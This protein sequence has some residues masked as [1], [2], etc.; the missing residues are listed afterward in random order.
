MTYG[1]SLRRLGDGLDT[2]WKRKEHKLGIFLEE[3][4]KREHNPSFGLRRET[5]T[6]QTFWDR[7]HDH[8][9]QNSFLIDNHLVSISNLRDYDLFSENC[10]TLCCSIAASQTGHI[11]ESGMRLLLVESQLDRRSI[12][13]S[14]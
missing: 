10:M 6:H 3:G 12:S 2:N 8:H 13:S 1:R 11:I 9:N 5:D 4:R 14:Q 7:T